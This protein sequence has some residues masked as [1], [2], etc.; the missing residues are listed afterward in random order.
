MSLA[1]VSAD[2]W[3]HHSG[4]VHLHQGQQGQ[5]WGEPL[6]ELLSVFWEQPAGTSVFSSPDPYRVA[7]ERRPDDCHRRHHHAAWL[8]RLLRRHQREPL[9]AAAGEI[10]RLWSFEP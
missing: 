10:A 5:Q 8:P 1:C 4:R 7:P 9:P 2:Q 3:V 6:R